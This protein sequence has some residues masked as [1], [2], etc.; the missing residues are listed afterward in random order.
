L[1]F[2][3]FVFFKKKK[4]KKKKIDCTSDDDEDAYSF[5]GCYRKGTRI[6]LLKKENVIP[7]LLLL[8]WRNQL[9]HLRFCF[10]P[11]RVFSQFEKWVH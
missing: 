6:L 3:F 1:G 5:G 10:D 4:K 11:N 7:F 8:T 2:F 9:R